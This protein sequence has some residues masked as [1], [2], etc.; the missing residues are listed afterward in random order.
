MNKQ[1]ITY[2]ITGVVVLGG[3]IWVFYT[4]PQK[5]VEGL[6][7]RQDA[8]GEIGQVSGS[9]KD[10]VALNRPLECTFNLDTQ[11]ASSKGTVFVADGNVRGNF[12]ISI[13]AMNNSSLEAFM[14]ADQTT[15]YVWSSLSTQ[16]FKVPL[17]K[18]TQAT[19]TQTNNGIS[20]NQ[21]LS[22][23]CKSWVKDVSVFIPP[24]NIT[25]VTKTN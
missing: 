13:T 16:G 22:Y 18:N 24:T 20:Y 9:M 7:G 25:F 14:I 15:S 19:T 11:Y 3:I 1:I 5:E 4:G 21:T 23:N 2:I 17:N 8:Q 6:P 10:L 12:T